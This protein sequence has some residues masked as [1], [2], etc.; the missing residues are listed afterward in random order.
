MIPHR[1][2]S[3]FNFANV[4]RFRKPPRTI[5]AWH[6]IDEEPNFL[7]LLILVVLVFA[8][9]LLC[10]QVPLVLARR[11]KLWQWLKS[12]QLHQSHELPSQSA[13]TY[14]LHRKYS[15]AVEKLG[16][17]VQRY[18]ALQIQLKVSA[19]PCLNFRTIF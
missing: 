5:V 14:N 9:V 10:R 15:H 4:Y 12:L 8:V 1:F 11:A 19:S 3:P 6:A 13:Q 18:Q 7:P 17:V 2:F 16:K